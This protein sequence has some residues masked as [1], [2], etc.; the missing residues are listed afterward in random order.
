MQ[1]MLIF[2]EDGE[3]FARRRGPQAREHMG[4]WMAY[5]SAIQQAGVAVSGAGLEPPETGTVVRLRNDAREVQDGPYAEAKEQLGGFF[6]IDVPD[7]DAALEWAA[8]APCASYGAVE[9]RPVMARPDQ[10]PA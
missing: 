1:Y 3:H 7:L 4:A 9:V 10:A 8:R 2:L 5:V 6:V